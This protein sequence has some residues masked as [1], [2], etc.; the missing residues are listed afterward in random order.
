VS[1]YLKKLIRIGGKK[2][3]RSTKRKK[4]KK[5]W[6]PCQF[7]FFFFFL[8]K[9]FSLESKRFEFGQ[10]LVTQSRLVRGSCPVLIIENYIA[11]LQPQ[12]SSLF[13][14]S[15]RVIFFSTVLYKFCLHFLWKS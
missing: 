10:C 4:K 11:S 5:I 12:L 1:H 3:L 13:Y 6:R 14:I 7:R 2:K 15:Y 9:M 8:K